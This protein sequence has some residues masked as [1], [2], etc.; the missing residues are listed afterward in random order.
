MCLICEK[1]KQQDDKSLMEAKYK[2]HIDNKVK[3]RGEK[4]YDKGIAQI[5]QSLKVYTFD[6]Q[7]VLATPC[8]TVIVMYYARKYATYNSTFYDL[9]TGE[10]YCYVWNES[11]GQ[12][13]SDEIG[14][15]IWKLH[16]DLRNVSDVI[17]YCD[18]CGGQNRNR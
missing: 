16:A 6:L 1:Y 14:T 9:A 15:S 8:S 10:G 5:D 7:S 2:E 13:G 11:D 4:E 12:R 3:A 17:L 18:S